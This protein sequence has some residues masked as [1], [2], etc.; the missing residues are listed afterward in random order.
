M[1]ENIKKLYTCQCHS[2]AI[3]LEFNPEDKE[4]YLTGWQ[5]SPGVGVMSFYN[6]LRWIW[7]ILTKGYPFNDHI[8]LSYDIARQVSND[9][10]RATKH[11]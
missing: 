6:R 9:I 1:Q 4:V 10:Y 2:E 11:K 8:I 5:M 7:H 3:T